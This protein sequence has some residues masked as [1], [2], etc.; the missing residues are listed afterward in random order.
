MPRPQR[1]APPYDVADVRAVLLAQAGV[2]ARGQLLGLGVTDADIARLVRRRT[3]HRL[4][5]G[6]FV[7]GT[8]SLTPLQRSWWACLHYD[9]SALADL[10]A[11]QLARDPTGDRL[12]LPITV[13]LPRG[14]GAAP[15]PEIQLRRVA[16]LEE[17]VVRVGLPRMK[18]AHAALRMAAQASD[19]N[20]V[21]AALADAVNWRTTTPQRMLRALPELPRLHQRSLIAEI[22]VDLVDGACSV[23]ERGYLTRV[24]RAHGLPAGQRQEPRRTA[25]GW[26]FRDVV[27]AAYQLV[28]ELDGRALHAEKRTRDRDLERDLD[29]LLAH[30]HSARLGYAQVFDKPC[31]TASKVARL[32]QQ[33]GWPGIPIPCRPGCEVGR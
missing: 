11:L 28:V 12:S 2:V 8:R 20:G 27:Y 22:L 1:K 19:E 18:P 30:R 32:L 7:E 29:D 16:Q 17:A 4:S 13:A 9:R 26:E 5:V 31:R 3:L 21:V 6:V 14:R 25:G 24:E 15:L 10:S 23:L 33:R